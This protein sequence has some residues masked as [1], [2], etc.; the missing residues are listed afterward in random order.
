M[1]IVLEEKS[2][3]RRRTGQWLAAASFSTHSPK[4]DTNLL[5]SLDFGAHFLSNGKRFPAKCSQKFGFIARH[6]NII[7]AKRKFFYF[8]AFIFFFLQFLLWLS[9]RP[10]HFSSDLFYRDPQPNR[11]TLHTFR[12]D[13]S[14]P[15][16]EPHV[17]ALANRPRSAGGGGKWRERR[18]DGSV[19][20]GQTT[21]TA[22]SILLSVNV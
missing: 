8:N 10:P 16:W 21:A 12:S 17:S 5:R 19:L 3:K 1:L 15:G 11:K 6:G 13:C 9:K 20:A 18:W 7:E 4:F 2:W 14:L 22:S